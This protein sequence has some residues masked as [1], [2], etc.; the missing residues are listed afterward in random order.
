MAAACLGVPE[1]PGAVRPLLRDCDGL[2][3]AV[4]EVLA[5]AVSSGELVCDDS[6]WR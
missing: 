4:E 5:A 3:F 6:G 1:L 2:P